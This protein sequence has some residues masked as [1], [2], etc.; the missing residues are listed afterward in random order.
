[1]GWV[2]V[3]SAASAPPTLLCFKHGKKVHEYI[4]DVKTFVFAPYSATSSV[5]KAW[6]TKQATLK[7]GKAKGK[8]VEV[9]RQKKYYGGEY[10]LAANGVITATWDNQDTFLKLTPRANDAKHFEG[11]IVLEEDFLF[12][13][14]CREP[15]AEELKK[16]D[17][18]FDACRM[19][20]VDAAQHAGIEQLMEEGRDL[21]E[22]GVHAAYWVK[23]NL[24]HVDI[25]Q[26]FSYEIKVKKSGA[27]C[28]VIELKKVDPPKS[29]AD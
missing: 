24:I 3:A 28:E 7:S 27:L 14:D 26:D 29:L 1:M 6:S 10:T 16:Y 9:R 18:G 19:S 21:D 15:S 8:K 25:D 12:E 4:G 22:L 11:E 5:L 2:G 23:K 13:V 20:A 17:Y